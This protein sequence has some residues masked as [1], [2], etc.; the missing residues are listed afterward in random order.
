MISNVLRAFN[1]D[2]PTTNA[3]PFG[4]GLINHTWLVTT[5]TAQ[6]ILQRINSK[7]FK[8]PYDIA[9]NIASIAKFLAHRYP[10]YT[11]V[12]PLQ[13]AEGKTTVC[14]ESEY[15]RLFPF[16]K[17]S[18]T[19]DVVNT[20]SQAFEAAAQF[21]KF[22][23][24]LAEF[25]VDQLNITIPDFH[26]LILRHDQFKRAL[27]MGNAKRINEAKDLLKTLAAYED[28]VHT[29]AQIQR[30]TAFKKRVTHHDTKISNVLFDEHGKGLCVI[31]LDTV[32][33][34]YFI[35]D[36][37]DMMR[38]YLS[39]VNEEESDF[40]RI[41]VRD[42][43]LQAV[44]KGYYNEMTSSL[45]PIEKRHFFFAGRFMIYMQ[46]IRFLT[47]Y[48]NNDSYYQVVYPE[49]NLVRAGNQAC[50]LKKLSEK[51]TLFQELM[52]AL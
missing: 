33:P 51:E 8:N 40:K 21:G 11:F 5:P 35:S 34:G 50:L 47:D 52:K 4:T 10:D 23:N 20:P 41:E 31:D 36:L 7:I 15:F 17:N 9:E 25:P 46:A 29:Y 48:L 32:M 3:K 24:I 45:S 42:E 43:F 1:L 30:D 18:V 6:Y 12:S 13:D 38:T 14:I 22:T 28:I 16:V 37:G 19:I 44:V 39:P 26:N 27:Q 2:L 49:Q